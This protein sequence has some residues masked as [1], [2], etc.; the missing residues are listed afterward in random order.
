[1]SEI[2]LRRRDS[3]QNTTSNDIEQQPN[4]NDSVVHGSRGQ[5]ELTTEDRADSNRTV[6]CGPQKDLFRI[7]ADQAFALLSA[8][9]GAS[10]FS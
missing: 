4:D 3:Q 6:R 9:F 10:I 7:A 2:E 1:M 8:S 5:S